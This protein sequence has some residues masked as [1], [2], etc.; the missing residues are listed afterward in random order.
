MVAAAAASPP[1]AIRLFYGFGAGL[2]GSVGLAFF[3]RGL[4]TA[5]M[6]VVAPIAATAV[7]VPLVVGFA[8][9]ERPST[10]QDA[11]IAVALLGV[12]LVSREPDRAGT[13]RVAAG[14]F[15][16]AAAAACFGVAL[17]GLSAASK[18][19]ALWGALSLRSGGTC[20][21]VIAAVAL[22]RRG[23]LPRQG[24]GNVAWLAFVGVVDVVASF[25]YADATTRS[26]LSI[27]AVLASLYPV[28]V[29]LLARALLDERL[30]R[31]QLAGAAAAL[32]GIALISAG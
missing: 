24:M 7:L 5:A 17:L 21:V 13:R 19:G 14:V 29:V 8:R 25:L 15:H 32:T 27:V 9:G 31:P 11:G 1:S 12:V 26:L 2:V 18:G 20:A 4:A 10:L 3:Y 22:G 6:G 30:A 28:L 16:A 23:V